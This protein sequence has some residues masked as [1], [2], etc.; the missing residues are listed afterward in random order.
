M[1]GSPKPCTLEIVGMRTQMLDEMIDSQK[2]REEQN[3][4]PIAEYEILL[5]DAQLPPAETEKE[6]K[7]DIEFLDVI[8]KIWLKSTRG[9]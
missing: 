2:V 6:M 5:T 7:A 9:G 4:I 1:H 3:N 8:S